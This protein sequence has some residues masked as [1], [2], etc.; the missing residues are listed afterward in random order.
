MENL[1]EASIPLHGLPADHS[2]QVPGETSSGL[3]RNSGLTE[4]LV[5]ACPGEEVSEKIRAELQ[6]FSI[7]YGSG[8]EIQARPHIRIARFQALEMMEETLIRWVQRI[9]SLRT[10]FTVTLNNYGG[11]PPG[12]IYL[13]VLDPRPFQQ[14]AMQ[15]RSV[16][17]FFRSP[18]NPPSELISKPSLRL[19]ETVPIE[20]FRHVLFDF[21][22][23]TFCESFLVNELWLLKKDDQ[24]GACKLVN[25]F[26][27]RPENSIGADPPDQ[28][29]QK[30]SV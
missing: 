22:S 12:T 20:V 29:N 3:A 2:E 17:D 25:M 16:D 26:R 19:T 4:Y 30:E 1:W 14:L 13:R 18:G 15:M 9:C 11:F 10:A 24:S 28:S 6:E 5:V 27:F 7:K 8:K 21:S 23:R